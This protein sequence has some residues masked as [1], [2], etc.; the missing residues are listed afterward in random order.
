MRKRRKSKG[1]MTKR[2]KK[3][4]K[5]RKKGNRRGGIEG[6]VREKNVNTSI[7]YKGIN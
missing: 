1:R 3:K 6:Q 2:R 4:G 7:F 5:R